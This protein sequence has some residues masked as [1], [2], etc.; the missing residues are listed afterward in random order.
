MEILH[1]MLEYPEVVKNLDFIKVSTF[2]LDLRA[3]VRLD[4]YTETECGA[5]ILAEV[6]VFWR[7]IDIDKYMLNTKN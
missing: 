7:L 1:L 2:P 3:G 6:E 4:Y 5:C